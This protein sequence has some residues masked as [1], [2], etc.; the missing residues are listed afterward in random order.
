M[1]KKRLKF[2]KAYLVNKLLRITTLT[3]IHFL[4]KNQI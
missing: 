3:K 2:K 1:I 4:I